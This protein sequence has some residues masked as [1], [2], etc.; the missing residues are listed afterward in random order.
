MANNSS[1]NMNNPWNATG[2]QSG[3]QWNDQDM[4]GDLLVQEKQLI[5]TYSTNMVE[6]SQHPLRTLMA[7]H[8]DQTSHDHFG[9]FQ[10]MQQRGWYQTQP[11]EENAINATRQRE[12]DH[13]NQ[14]M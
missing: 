3:Q 13:R 4:I 2:G 7:Q 1:N 8:L 14:M 6:G 11:A 5:S 9:L 12:T 10:Q